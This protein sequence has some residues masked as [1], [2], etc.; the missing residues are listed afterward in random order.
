MTPERLKELREDGYAK[1]LTTL[2]PLK[3]DSAFRLEPLS[4]VAGV[5]VSR[6]GHADVKLYFDEKSHLLVKME[7]Q[8]GET[9]Y[10]AY[11]D[12]DGVKR[13]T[14]V[15]QTVGGKKFL[16][17]TEVSYKFPRKVEEATFAKP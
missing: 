17:V 4:G 2:L 6:A 14:R 15:V 8:A 3:K 11:R 16:E 12:F 10:S 9:T 1:W 5:K 7:R 13:P